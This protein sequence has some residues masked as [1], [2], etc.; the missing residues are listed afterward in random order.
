MEEPSDRRRYGDKEI[1][2]ILKRAA[3]LQRQ[4]PGSGVE[5][6]GLSLRELEEVAA[7][8]GIDPRHLRRAAVEIE[9]GA[10]GLEKEGF[11]RLIG[12]PLTVSFTRSLPGEFP[13]EHFD[14]LVDDIQ[15]TADGQGGA[16]ALGRKLTWRS[17][18]PNEVR[19]LMVNVVSRDG[20]TSIH[21]EERLS[22]LAGGLYGGMMARGGLGIGLGVGDRESVA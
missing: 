15:A 1:G 9:A 14:R 2:L 18:S 22:Q 5:G 11:A 6:G 7:E 21:I 13:P 16:S 20:H 8:A 10:A 4:E 19:S 17:T 12:G 3:E